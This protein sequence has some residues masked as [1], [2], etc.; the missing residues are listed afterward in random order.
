[1]MTSTDKNET[2]NPTLPSKL[3]ELETGIFPSP[4]PVEDQLDAHREKWERE[5]RRRVLTD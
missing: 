1:M 3:S 2:E 5:R 4:N